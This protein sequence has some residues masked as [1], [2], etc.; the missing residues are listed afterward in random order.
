MK[1][2]STARVQ[3][4]RGF[5]SFGTDVLGTFYPST[6]GLRPIVPGGPEKARKW[7]QRADLGVNYLR[8]LLPHCSLTFPNGFPLSPTIVDLGK[9]SPLSIPP[10]IIAYL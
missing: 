6:T 3:Y 7:P 10:M 1:D 8:G 9:A 5:I 2:G 4:Y